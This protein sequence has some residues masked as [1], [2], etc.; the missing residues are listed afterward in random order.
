MIFPISCTLLE[1][2][3]LRGNGASRDVPRS[4]AEALRD[5]LEKKGCGV[6]VRGGQRGKIKGRRGSDSGLAY[7]ITI[8]MSMP[9]PIPLLPAN[10][11]RE[12]REA[13]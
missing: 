11:S 7:L 10:L 8:Y 1:K 5:V 4:P 3:S 9:D 2:A 13:G 12:A 6:T